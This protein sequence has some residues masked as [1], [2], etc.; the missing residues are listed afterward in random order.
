VSRS[1][2]KRVGDILAASKELADIVAG[3]KTAFD[4]DR[5]QQLAVERLLEI[6]GEAAR[7]MSD[8]ARASYPDIVWERPIGLRTLLVHAYHRV[9][10]EQLWEAAARSVPDMVKHLEPSPQPPDN[11]G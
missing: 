4:G 6:I 2:D 11:N 1:D 5:T 3:G 8:D 7:A 10:P 9:D